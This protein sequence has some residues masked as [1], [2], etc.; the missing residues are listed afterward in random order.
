MDKKEFL[1]LFP[2]MNLIESED[3]REKC[4]NVW[5]EVINKSTWGKA[6]KVL[7]CPCAMGG[8][9]LEC[10]EKLIDHSRR[11]TRLCCF[12]ADELRD[13][14][15]KIGPCNKEYLVAAATI[16]DVTKLL[17]YTYNEEDGSIVKNEYLWKYF[18]HPISG[19]Y[20]AKKFDLPDEIVYA[21][22]A[23]SSF[24]SPRGAN[25]PRTPESYLMMA[26]DEIVFQYARLYY[27]K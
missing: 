22:L 15:E 17:E 14:F 26:I 27:G 4:T 21:V 1:A 19:A 12:M 23:H 2:E 10:P 5:L 25:A 9:V 3:L 6:G 11:V 8:L 16:H 24:F 13:F 18:P 7:E 20:L